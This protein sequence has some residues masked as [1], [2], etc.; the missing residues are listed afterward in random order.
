MAT[1]AEAIAVAKSQVPIDIAAFAK[2]ENQ[3]ILTTDPRPLT[4]TRW[5]DGVQNAQEEAVKA[6]GV[7]VYE[8]NR[9]DLVA[10]WVLNTLR[11][12][13]P[14]K[15]GTYVL[16]H[17]LFLNGQEV[18]DLKTWKRGDEITITNLVP[19][20]RKIEIGTAHGK[21]IKLSVSPHIYERTA[22]EARRVYRDIAKIE[23]TYRGVD[24]GSFVKASLK[25]QK[26]MR[27]PVIVITEPR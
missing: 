22:Q 24:G 6:G 12:R 16:S 23:F 27:Y 20:A 9:Y 10:E 5:V 8:Y 21:P 3:K 4:F 13:S 14:V 25:S 18:P 7:I 2:K 26:K 19:Y 11:Q 1:F 17:T 15:S